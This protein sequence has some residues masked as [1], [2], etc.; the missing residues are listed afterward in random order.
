MQ[1]SVSNL[2]LSTGFVIVNFRTAY[3]M[4]AKKHGLVSSA[5]EKHSLTVGLSTLS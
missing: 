1:N 5:S 3:Y 4:V 2:I